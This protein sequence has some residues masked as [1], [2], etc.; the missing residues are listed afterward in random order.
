MDMRLSPPISVALQRF[1]ALPANPSPEPEVSNSSETQKPEG[2]T[3]N[4][5]SLPDNK[6]LIFYD[7]ECPIC[8]K[9]KKRL[10]S[11]DHTQKLLF[12]PLQDPMVGEK[13]PELDPEAMKESMHVVL[14]NRKVFTGAAG[15]CEIGKVVSVRSFTGLG[16]KMFSL[17]MKVPG[18]LFLAEKAYGMVARNRY[19]LFG[20][21]VTG[22]CNDGQC[23]LDHAPP[24]APGK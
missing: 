7:G 1:D 5:P 20:I 22:G 24:K 16:F 4:T 15:Y 13:F 9:A 2:S 19:K 21:Q 12:V 17:A 10:E 6:V 8:Q 11:I 14:P 23:T 18:L 3:K